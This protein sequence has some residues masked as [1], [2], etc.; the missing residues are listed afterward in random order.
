VEVLSQ[1]HKR[2]LPQT[3]SGCWHRMA[4]VQTLMSLCIKLFGGDIE[5]VWRGHVAQEHHAKVITQFFA[6]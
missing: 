5:L 1:V 2:V 4:P 6:N 3:L